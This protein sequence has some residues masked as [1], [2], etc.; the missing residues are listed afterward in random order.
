MSTLK[1]LAALGRIADLMLDQRLQVLLRA[2]DARTATKDRI[3]ALEQPQ[4][5]DA[6]SLQ[7]SV[8]AQMLYQAWAD[9]RRKDL[10]LVLAK[11]TVKVMEVES[12][13]RLAFG[14]QSALRQL[15]DKWR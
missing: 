1:Q 8:Q 10:N 9:M 4:D 5:L 13:A 14:K 2:Q 11:Q 15:Q 6:C 12:D 3:A 7:A